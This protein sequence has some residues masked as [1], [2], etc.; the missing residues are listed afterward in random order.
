[1]TPTGCWPGL[2]CTSGRPTGRLL[3]AMAAGRFPGTAVAERLGCARCEHA[4]PAR[5]HQAML[6][7]P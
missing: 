4:T 7:K 2:G 1:M 3:I 5:L 6:A